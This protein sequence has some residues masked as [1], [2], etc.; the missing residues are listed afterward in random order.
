MSR[1]QVSRRALAFATALIASCQASAMGIGDIER[2]STLGN[3]LD[4]LIP[5]SVA[6]EDELHGAVARIAADEL[7]EHSHLQRLGLLDRARVDVV[8]RDGQSYLRVTTAEPVREPILDLVIELVGLDGATVRRT[9]SVL[10]DPPDP[11]AASV[12][13]AV[14]E[15]PPAAKR[16]APVAPVAVAPLAAPAA[17][18]APPERSVA[19]P[20]HHAARRNAS[21]AAGPRPSRP[22]REASVNTA[23]RLFTPVLKLSETLAEVPAPPASA[24]PPPQPVAPQPPVPA[25]MPAPSAAPSPV[26]TPAR[27]L[28]DEQTWSTWLLA[29]LLALVVAAAAWLRRR[30]GREPGDDAAARMMSE[31]RRSLQAIRSQSSDAADTEVVPSPVVMPA[32]AVVEAKPAYVPPPREQTVQAEAPLEQHP[33]QAMNFY[34]DVAALLLGELEKDPGRRDLRY[35]LIEVYYAANLKEEFREQTR[36]YLEQLQGRSD[37]HWPEIVRMGRQLLPDSGLYSETPQLMTRTVVQPLPIAQVK[38]QSFQRYYEAVNQARLSARQSELEKAW[39]YAT[40]DP[41][42]QS[43]FKTEMHRLLQR[44]T[45]L[46][47]AE[48]LSAEFG[49]AQL[50][51]KFED[52]RGAEDIPQINAIGQVLLARHMGKKRVVTATITGQ[53]GVAVAGAARDLGIDCA[54]YMKDSDQIKQAERVRRMRDLGASVLSTQ[55]SMIAINDDVRVR[56]L[57]DW[58]VDGDHT[59]YINSLDAGPYPYPA[60]VLYFQGVVGREVKAQM[61]ERDGAL[62][63]AVIVSNADGLSAI[64]LLEGLL[65]EKAIRLYCVETGAAVASDNTRH[66]FGREHSW[67]KASG[68]VT[69]LSVPESDSRQAMDLAG[70]SEGWTLE[71]AAGEVL[72]QARRVAKELGPDKRVVAMLPK[73]ETAAWEAALRVNG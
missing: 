4:I 62:P 17:A 7:Y 50:L 10:L 61:R 38:V 22:L 13:A 11:A 2:Q 47:V 37:E 64:G 12:P 19:A 55:A 21:A 70:L 48:K 14:R 18:S 46:E 58:M 44:P 51:R 24:A 71:L 45:P 25:P 42:F 33:D 68:R 56:A 6:D 53:H 3:P 32:V 20:R 69:Y 52:R 23:P 67:L 54:I 1:P 36:F 41:E 59:L 9:F 39:D 16:A 8:A 35:K 15:A 40:R 73:A 49:G 31:M 27:E 63:D 26:A 5:L 34:Q 43:A 57:E 30:R 60:I 72:A 65:K 28:P 29:A 66:R